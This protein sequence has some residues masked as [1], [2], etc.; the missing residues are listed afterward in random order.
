MNDKMKTKIYEVKK[1]VKTLK[2]LCFSLIKVKQ[3]L[4]LII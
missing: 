4:L 1:T 2:N 3:T